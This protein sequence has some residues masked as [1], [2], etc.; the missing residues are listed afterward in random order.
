[1]SAPM[2]L[3]LQAKKARAKA[4]KD[5]AKAKAKRLK[6]RQSP[7]RLKAEADRLFS[8]LIR[9][10]G[11]CESGRPNHAGPLQC[12]HGFSRRYMGTRW[13]T[14][15]AWC[16][17]AGCHVYWTHRPIEWDEWMRS[18]LGNN[19]YAQ[20]RCRALTLTTPDIP[21]RVSEL[22]ERLAYVALAH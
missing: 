16:L 5:K 3:A 11:H 6:L 2:L 9:A 7:K 10:R 4:N 21:E 17:C 20:L 1:M 14:A 12:A 8:L 19:L 18:S 15:N 22:R 13:V